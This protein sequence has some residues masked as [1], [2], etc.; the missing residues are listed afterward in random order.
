APAEG[1]DSAVANITKGLRAVV[2]LMRSKAP[3]AVIVVTAIFPR[4][5]NMAVMPVIDGVNRNLEQFAD[6][7]AIR[8]L[9]INSKLADS[10][11]KL[12]E[13]MMNPDKLHPAVKGYA[14]WAEALK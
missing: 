14:V 6:G 9:N 4:N 5:D 3:R 8:Y 10:S 7:K 12:F 1:N 2:D 13:G 11:G